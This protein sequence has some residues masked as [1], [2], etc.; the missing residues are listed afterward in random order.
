LAAV[1]RSIHRGSDFMSDLRGVPT[2]HDRCVVARNL[3]NLQPLPNE[4][5]HCI[6]DAAWNPSGNVGF[7]IALKKMTFPEY[8][9]R[10]YALI[11]V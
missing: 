2:F 11:T 6:S 3:F 4:P 9:A 10:R 7:S 1:Y 8:A 5:F